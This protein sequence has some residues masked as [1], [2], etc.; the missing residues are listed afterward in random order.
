MLSNVVYEDDLTNKTLVIGCYAKSLESNISFKLRIRTQINGIVT[1][2]P[3]QSFELSDS[4]QYYEFQYDVSDD[5]SFVQLQV[6]LGAHTGTYFLD[7]FSID[8]I[9]SSLGIISEVDDLDFVL[10]PN[11]TKEFINIK[12]F[13]EIESIGI[14]SLL[15]RLLI[16]KNQSEKININKLSSGFYLVKVKFKNQAMIIQKILKK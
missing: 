4:Y 12:S 10:Y 14:Y 16:M 11:P 13:N 6:L 1:Y 2:Q 3:S 7:S 15:G 5:S 9:D 8:V